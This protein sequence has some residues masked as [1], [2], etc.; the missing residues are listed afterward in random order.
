MRGGALGLWFWFPESLGGCTYPSFMLSVISCRLVRQSCLFFDVA[1]PNAFF[2]CLLF[3]V[4]LF[5]FSSYVIADTRHTPYLC[6]CCVTLSTCF[7]NC[8]WKFV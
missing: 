6:R 3:V 4:R 5:V 2:V 8:C 1:S 7:S